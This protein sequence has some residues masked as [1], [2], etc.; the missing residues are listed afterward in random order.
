MIYLL[1]FILTV[2]SLLSY[3]LCN[4]NILSPGFICCVMYTLAGVVVLVYKDK[5]NV[6]IHA[7]TILIIILFLFLII[8]GDI[9]ATLFKKNIRI[10]NKRVVYLN[11]RNGIMVFILLLMLLGA[12]FYS[13][14]TFELYKY[15][16]GGSNYSLLL[17]YVRY[18][19]NQMNIGVGVLATV[20]AWIVEAMFLVATY[21]FI[22]NIFNCKSTIKKEIKY[23]FP[24]IIHT[25]IAILSAGRTIIMREFIF[26]AVLI[27]V[28]AYRRNSWSAK[29]NG[30]IIRIAI[31]ASCI[32][33]LTF[34]SL[35]FLTGKSENAIL[36][37]NVAIY[38][39]SP[40]V[41]LNNYLA[42]PVINIGGIWGGNTLYGI[43]SALGKIIETIPDLSSPLEFI[44]L[45]ETFSTNIYTPIRR[46]FQD[47]GLTGVIFIAFFIGFIYKFLLI[48]VVN[49]T[50][51]ALTILYAY[52][53][54]PLIEIMIEERLFMD[55]ISL[56]T[57][58]IIV[59]VTLTYK[60]FV[61]SHIGVTVN[62]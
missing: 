41:A 18:A 49:K 46:Y 15:S 24:M 6:M 7:E 62:E 25:Y 43:Y 36:F 3:L 47:F 12:V 42:D 32:F 50:Q 57:I 30:K 45:S 59:T 8:I 61:N 22:N 56:K 28:F 10:N 21:V 54:Y 60:G 34:Y 1:V 4:K 55:L 40:L 2:L 51:D 5:W 29:T 58:M 31:I 26:I 27:I 16:G 48:K 38:I 17:Y 19:K 39:G 13:I 20:S 37:D 33:L 35:G 44:N 53:F 23:I 52:A 11:I 9:V 14:R